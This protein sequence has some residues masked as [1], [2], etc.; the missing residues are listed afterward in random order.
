MPAQ[1][2]RLL[3]E[4]LKK[5][6]SDFVYHEEPGQG[7]WWDLSPEAGVDCVDWA[8]MFDFFARRVRAPAS[9]R[10]EID[11]R[12]ASPGVSARCEWVTIVGQ[13][14]PHELSRVHV[15]CVPGERV[16]GRN[17]DQPRQGQARPVEER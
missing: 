13:E 4:E 11:F 5:F 17:A 1:Q 12:T 3:V 8:P 9:S 10:V 15:R 16:R 6:H 7:H 2:S 14:H